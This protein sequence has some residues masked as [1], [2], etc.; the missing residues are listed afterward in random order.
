MIYT[1]KSRNENLYR[2]NGGNADQNFC[3][4]FPYVCHYQYGA[5]L[6][7]NITFPFFIEHQT[8]YLLRNQTEKKNIWIAWMFGNNKLGPEGIHQHVPHVPE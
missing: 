4:T 2:T 3:N 7:A 5:D 1:G 8:K 6:Y